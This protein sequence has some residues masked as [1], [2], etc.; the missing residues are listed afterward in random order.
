M[1]IERPGELDRLV[2]TF[3][4]ISSLREVFA[5]QYSLDDVFNRVV[6]AARRAIRDA[7]GV[8]ITVLDG[9]GPRTA[10]WTDD[11]A[12]ALDGVQYSGG[13]GPCLCA[14]QSGRP[15]RVAVPGDGR[16]PHFTEAARRRGVSATLSAPL[17]AG[18]DEPGLVGSL[19]VY[20]SRVHA[21][22][23]FD[24][25]LL[26][27][28]LVSAGAAAADARRRQQ[29]RSATD[30]LQRA[31]TSR[32]VIDQAKGALRAIHGCSAEEAFDRL[33]RTS[34][35]SNVKVHIVAQELLDSLRAGADSR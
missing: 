29:T 28:Y 32:A 7:D 18:G 19:N 4:A 11:D 12:H 6:Q 17:P 16:W 3:E 22:D 10:A 13:D 8:S 2:H 20:S 5:T 34:Q 35:H 31:L 30:N 25:H 21:F 24:E 33:V 26:R 23:P 27:V 9:S 15:V 14:A 1:P